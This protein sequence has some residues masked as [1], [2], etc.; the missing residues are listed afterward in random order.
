MATYLKNFVILAL[1]IGLNLGFVGIKS[2]QVNAQSTP[3]TLK[4]VYATATTMLKGVFPVNHQVTGGQIWAI[5]LLSNIKTVIG[6]L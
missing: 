1:G 3:F 4:L 6:I 2:E 5:V